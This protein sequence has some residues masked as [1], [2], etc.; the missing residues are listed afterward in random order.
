MLG[1]FHNAGVPIMLQAF[2][3]YCILLKKG[4]T[5][6]WEDI[7]E[8]ERSKYHTSHTTLGALLA[9]QWQLPK[10]MIEVIY[11]FHDT[12]GI[13]NSGELSRVSLYL[14]SI[15]KL[16]RSSIDGILRGDSNTQEWQ[17][18]QDSI[19]EFLG[20]DEIQLDDMREKVLDAFNEEE[21]E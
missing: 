19:L 17:L 9:Q 15:L 18:L 14:L 2:D 6:G 10:P 16:S 1:L 5:D 20:L 3:D 13:F 11:Y 8:L 4:I 12:E 7:G 21:E